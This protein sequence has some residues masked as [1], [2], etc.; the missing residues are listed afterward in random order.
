MQ[1]ERLDDGQKLK[2]QYIKENY[3]QLGKYGNNYQI[4]NDTTLSYNPR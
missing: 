2:A 4:K 1:T 3:L